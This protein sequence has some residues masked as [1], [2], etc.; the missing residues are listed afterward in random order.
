MTC[1]KLRVCAYDAIE[2]MARALN[3]TFREGESLSS[4]LFA[5]HALRPSGLDVRASILG[6]LHPP[7]SVYAFGKG[8]NGQLGHGDHWERPEPEKVIALEGK[9]VEGVFAGGAHT[10]FLTADRLLRMC[11][12]N[13]HGEL[14]DH[15]LPKNQFLPSCLNWPNVEGC[16]FGM[17]HMAVCTTDGKL[18][19]CGYA[20][21]GQLGTPLDVT[22]PTRVVDG[23][24]ERKFIVQ[25][26]CGQFHTVA[27]TRDGEVF[28]FGS[29]LKGVTGLPP[30]LP[31]H[32]YG[33]PH[34]VS[35]DG[36]KPVVQVYAS[37]VRTAVLTS[38]GDVYTFGRQISQS[39]LR[40]FNY[41]PKKAR[42]TGFVW[43]ARGAS[44]AWR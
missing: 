37:G 28:S 1:G 36:G 33:V 21:D 5:I 18:W 22:A 10:A 6:G 34:K 43:W 15:T 42:I 41:E 29:K 32:V 19:T 35:V 30:G 13:S 23:E 20:R 24:L 16:A 40:P 31:E 39:P 11:G 38:D 8:E 12:A 9:R 27:L 4:Q 7:T 17:Y 25:V 26:A 3:L 2:Q 14:G 44:G